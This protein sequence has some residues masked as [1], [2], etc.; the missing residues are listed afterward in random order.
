MR[1]TSK[2][3]LYSAGLIMLIG[4]GTAAGSLKYGIG[5]L[6]RMGPGYFPLGLGI[7]LTLI[8]ALLIATPLTEQDAE[9]K[10]PWKGQYRAW[11]MV[12]AGM[13]AFMVL[14]KYGGL[15][16]ATFALIFVSALGDR[17]NSIKA[18]FALA[19]GVTLAAVAIFHYGLQMQFPLFIWG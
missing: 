11:L 16:P 15:V 19:T 13:M 14:G 4:I 5:T 18:A 6:A 3:E 10:S 12:I 9:D 8:G 7:M 17:N 2:R 1:I